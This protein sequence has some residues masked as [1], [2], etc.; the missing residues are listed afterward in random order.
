MK[1][2]IQNGPQIDSCKLPEQNRH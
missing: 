2:G 1:N